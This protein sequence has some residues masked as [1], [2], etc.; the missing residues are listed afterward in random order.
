MCVNSALKQI[1]EMN[2]RLE[3]GFCHR[4]CVGSAFIPLSG[5]YFSQKINSK[6]LYLTI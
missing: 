2:F 1:C 5:R 6:L 4:Q 3:I